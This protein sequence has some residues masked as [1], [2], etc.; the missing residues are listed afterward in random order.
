MNSRISQ[1]KHYGQRISGCE[2][3]HVAVIFGLAL[4]VILGIAAFAIDGVS[5][6]RQVSWMQNTADS[7][8]LA[9]AKELHIYRDKPDELT[10]VGRARVE[11]LLTAA[12]FAGRPHSV[13]VSVDQVANTVDV[14][15]A[16]VAKSFVPGHIWSENPVQ[17]LSVARAFGNA[18]LCVLGLNRSASQTIKA[19]KGAVIT[20]PEC[21]VQSNSSDPQS[22]E[23]IGA[24]RI[25]S[26]GTCSSG[27]ITGPDSITPDPETDCPALD[28]PLSDRPP[29]N[30]VGCDFLDFHVEEGVSTISPGTYCGGIKMANKAVVYAEPGIYVITGGKLD[31]GNKTELLGEK[32]SFYF[33]DDA[34][35]FEF[36]DNG[37]VEL[38]APTDG[39]MAGILFYENPAAPQGR[40]FKI[41]S[42]S[43]RKLLGTIYLPR[44]ILEISGG[45]KVAQASAYTVILANRIEIE[46]SNL[47]VNSDYEG[48]DVP[49]P[50]GVG[51]NS[52]STMLER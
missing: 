20:A 14:Q 15:I 46:T 33:A 50:D 4:P 11:A 42:D 38:S 48:S 23:V 41:S 22:L 7:A 39:P 19:A 35:T 43:A 18:R 45:G 44:A 13:E 10:A 2:G 52:T 40:R 49:V 31:L 27:G 30:V 26:A 6:N 25:E 17:V 36:K 51:P 16:M 28:D 8:A 3:G 29:P 32:V 24:S 9:V 12:G 37:I 21:A 47:V 1:P 34:A 5:I